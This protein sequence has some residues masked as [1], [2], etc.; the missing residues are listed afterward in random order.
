M[1]SLGD[2]LNNKLGGID[3]KIVITGASGWIGKALVETLYS[4]YGR[5][6]EKFVFPISV[7]TKFIKLRNGVK[8]NCYDYEQILKVSPGNAILWHLAFLTKDKCQDLSLEE[9]KQKNLS[10][11]N[12]V[13]TIIDHFNVTGLVYASSGAVYER[14]RELANDFEVNPYGY[15]K[16]ADETFF[17]DLAKQKGFSL[18]V[19]RIFNISGPYMNKLSLYALSDFIVQAITQKH[20]EIKAKRKVVRSYVFLEDFYKLCFSMLLGKDR[21]ETYCVFD[22]ANKQSVE[23][24]ELATLVMSELGQE[25]LI[26]REIDV[27]LTDNVYVGDYEKFYSL[28]Q[29]YKIDITS[30]KHQVIDAI[31]YISNAAECSK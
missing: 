4:C 19:P 5:E 15:L 29:E 12:K 6:I 23:L 7:S 24:E 14:N 26:E 22:V 13:I 25:V 9:Y 8:I 20:I 21:E 17:K 2:N 31:S 18:L 28:C 1:L 27:T 16:V 10:I 3:T 11:R 30:C